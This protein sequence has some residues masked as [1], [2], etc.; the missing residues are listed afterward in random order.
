MPAIEDKRKINQKQLKYKIMGCDIHMYVEYKRKDSD[1]IDN[2]GSRINPGRNYTLFGLLAKGVRRDIPEGVE[3][4]G[5]PADKLG[6]RTEQD[7]H[8]YISDEYANHDGYCSLEKAIE[9]G[10]QIIKDGAGN[11]FKTLHPDWHSHSWLTVEEYKRVID[12]YRSEYESTVGKEPEYYALL[13]SMEAF[14]NSGYEPRIVYWFD[15]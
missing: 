1:F 7:L 2:F 14:K 5:I 4:K 6:G 15:N 10:G 11:P 8:L 12:L 3:P 13:A 9:W